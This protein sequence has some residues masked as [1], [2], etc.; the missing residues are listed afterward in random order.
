MNVNPKKFLGL[1]LDNK[2]IFYEHI[3]HIKRKIAKRIGALYRSKYL[4]GGGCTALLKCKHM[5]IQLKYT[6]PITQTGS[7]MTGGDAGIVVEECSENCCITFKFTN[8]NYLN[9]G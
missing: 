8:D 2:L 4:S 9:R 6:S 3:D 5:F 7:S 1:I